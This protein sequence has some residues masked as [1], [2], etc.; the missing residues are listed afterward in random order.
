MGLK[1]ALSNGSPS[2]IIAACETGEEAA[3]HLLRLKAEEAVGSRF[4]RNID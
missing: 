4:Q 3:V 2:A 1:S